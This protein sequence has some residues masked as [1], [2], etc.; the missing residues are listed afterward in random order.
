M[1]TLIQVW[2]R[3]TVGFTISE[4]AAGSVPPREDLSCVAQTQT[5]GGN[6]IGVG[7]WI[8]GWMNG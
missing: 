5:V 6:I 4:S 2:V 7:G 1:G 8:D 3:V